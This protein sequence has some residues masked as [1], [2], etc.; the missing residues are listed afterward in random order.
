MPTIQFF[1]CP[2]PV[3]GNVMLNGTNQG[4]NKDSSG[5]LLTKKCGEGLQIISLQC[6]NGKKCSPPQVEIEIQYTDPISPLE[7][8]FQCA[9]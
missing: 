8:P 7:V 4:P 2:C 3:T 1:R 9:D 5:K 6:P